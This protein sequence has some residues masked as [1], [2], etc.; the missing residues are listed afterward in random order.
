VLNLLAAFVGLSLPTAL[1]ATPG[2]S[3]G[4][5][6]AVIRIEAET[7]QLAGGAAVASG[8]EGFSGSGYVTGFKADTDRLT[9]AFPCKAGLYAIA[10]RYRSP[11]KG[12]LYEV[13]GLTLSGRFVDSKG[14]FAEQRFGF[15]RMERLRD[16]PRGP[17][18]SRQASGPA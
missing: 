9:L 5:A 7:G 3:A 18:S 4:A 1:A 12:F 17:D 14:A 6:P 11:V 15:W 16:R 10:I 13:N 8:G 2:Q